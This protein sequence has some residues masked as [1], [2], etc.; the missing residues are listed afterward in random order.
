MNGGDPRRRTPRPVVRT[1]REP[2]EEAVDDEIAFHL[3]SRVGE[4]RARGFSET[5]ARRLAMSE[6]GDIEASRRELAAVDRTLR[7]RQR[8]VT[9][10]DGCGQGLRHVIRSLRHAPTFG[11]AGRPR[12]NYSSRTNPFSRA[13]LFAR[14]RYFKNR[15]DPH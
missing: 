13:M 1:G 11:I 8:I 2:I 15:D 4:L 12:G 5:D 9:A 14:S 7:R 6:Y 3:E 10:F